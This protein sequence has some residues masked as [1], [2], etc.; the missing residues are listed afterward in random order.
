[1][2]WWFLAAGVMLAAPAMA[3]DTPPQI[4]Q[5]DGSVVVKSSGDADGSAKTDPLVQ[6]VE[7]ALKVSFVCADTG[8]AGSSSQLTAEGEAGDAATITFTPMADGLHASVAGQ[9]MSLVVKQGQAFDLRIHWSNGHR[10]SF[11]LYRTDPATGIASMESRDV[12]LKGN[13]QDLS[14]KAS[15]GTLTLLSQSYLLR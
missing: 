13:V 9:A 14:F 12:Q 6:V 2:R 10:V 15:H 7:T 8:C 5:S 11:D 4:I 3:Q 1:M